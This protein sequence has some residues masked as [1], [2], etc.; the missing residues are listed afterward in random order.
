M[1]VELFTSLVWF[2]AFLFSTT[3]HEAMHAFVAWKGGDPTA[4]PWRAVSLSPL[5][6]IKREPMGM[7]SCRS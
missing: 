7:L 6:H 1:D 2:G 4:L 5:P 3:V